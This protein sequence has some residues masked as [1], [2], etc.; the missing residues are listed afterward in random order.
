ML[1]RTEIEMLLGNM[2]A[3]NGKLKTL[4]HCDWSQKKQGKVLATKSS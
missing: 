2:N 3:L 1:T 4:S